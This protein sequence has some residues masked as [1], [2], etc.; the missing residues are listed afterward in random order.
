[1]QGAAHHRRTVGKELP[2]HTRRSPNCLNKHARAVNVGV[3]G[4]VTSLKQ[5]EVVTMNCWG[6]TYEN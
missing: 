2:K 1:M 4:W 3:G 6:N 5:C